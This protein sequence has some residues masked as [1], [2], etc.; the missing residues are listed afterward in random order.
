MLKKLR[1]WIKNCLNPNKAKSDPLDDW[2]RLFGEVSR[3]EDLVR[4]ENVNEMMR[5]NPLLVRGGVPGTDVHPAVY[6]PRIRAY[7]L[8]RDPRPCR[9]G[10][11]RLAYRSWAGDDHDR[12]LR[13]KVRMR[14]FR[15][16]QGFLCLR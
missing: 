13:G 14:L 16:V 12:Y 5:S 15:A 2:Y 6:L 9:K 11:A 10:E 7:D 4:V 8:H 1:I 3:A